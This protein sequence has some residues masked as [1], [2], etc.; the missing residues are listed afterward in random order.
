MLR[1]HVDL[2]LPGEHFLLNQNGC[3]YVLLCEYAIARTP[4]QQSGEPT[5]LLTAIA[6]YL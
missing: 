2:K 4:P 6:C 1:Y 3:M 5:T